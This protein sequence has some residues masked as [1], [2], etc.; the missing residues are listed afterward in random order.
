MILCV[1]PAPK[2]LN[3]NAYGTGSQVQFVEN[4]VLVLFLAG[5]LP[6][7]EVFREEQKAI[8][9]RTQHVVIYHFA[10]RHIRGQCGNLNQYVTKA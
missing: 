6:Q 7:Q 10:F 1:S 2:C 9:I 5:F 3:G 4:R 8:P